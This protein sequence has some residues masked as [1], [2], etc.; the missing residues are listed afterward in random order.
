MKVASLIE[1]LKQMQSQQK[2]TVVELKDMKDN[3]E[4]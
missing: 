3:L 4:K 1:S 2:T